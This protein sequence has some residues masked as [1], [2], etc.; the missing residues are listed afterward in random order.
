M[1]QI[2]R[3]R[4]LIVEFVHLKKLKLNTMQ[5]FKTLLGQLKITI[6][7]VNRKPTNGLIKCFCCDFRADYEKIEEIM[8]GYFKDFKRSDNASGF[9]FLDK[10]IQR[11]LCDEKVYVAYNVKQQ[12]WQV[13]RSVQTKKIIEVEVAVE[14]EIPHVI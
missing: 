12:R 11:L 3:Y 2:A 6:D 8:K 1:V 7:S 4:G 10:E 5:K 13:M 9:S 14:V